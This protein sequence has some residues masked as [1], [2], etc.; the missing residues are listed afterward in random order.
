ME[1]AEKKNSG[2]KNWIWAL[3]IN[4]VIAGAVL[5]LTDMTYESGDDYAVSQYIVDGYPYASFVNYYLCRALIAVQSHVAQL[6]VY[7]IFLILISFLSFVYIT[8][9]VFDACGSMS[10]RIVLVSALVIYSFDHYCAIQFT[11]TAALVTTAGFIVLTDCVIKHRKI[12]SYAAALML[13]YLGAAIR[14]GTF[15]AVL[16]TAAVSVMTWMLIEFAGHREEGWFDAKSLISTAVIIALVCGAFG[17][18]KLSALK[19]TSTPELKLYEE[20]NLVRSNVLDYPTLEYYED[21]KAEYDA[22]GLSENDVLM[23]NNWRLDYDG[24]ASLENLKKIDAIERPQPDTKTKAVRSIKKALGTVLY[25]V[26]GMSTAGIHII[27]LFVIAAGMVLTLRPKHWFYVLVTGAVTFGL[28]CLL[29]YRDRATYRVMYIADIDA[30]LWLLYYWA[31]CAGKDPDSFRK[32]LAVVPAVLMIVFTAASIGPLADHC[33]AKYDRAGSRLME[34]ATAAYLKEH[35]DKAFIWGTG[36]R[37]RTDK[38]NR[39]WLAPDD[40]DKNAFGTGG[41]DVM[42]PYTLDHMAEYGI[43]NPIKDLIDND[44]VRYIGNELTEPLAQYLTDWYAGE[45][46]V[47]VMKKTDTVDGIAVWKAERQKR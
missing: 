37:K 39:P 36:E 30:T 16:G 28:Y 11:K 9:I 29:Y 32:K 3:C 23:I 24:A 34:E 42:S 22:I 45:G 31:V 40:S 43:S 14:Y 1:S 5:A 41:W 25:S 4:G 44:N 17:I 46:E 35:S 13:I 15:T 21:K 12:P 19:N 7:V 38:Y 10:V 18:I 26:T 2:I 33:R 20:Y 27:A 47:I 6:N 8:K